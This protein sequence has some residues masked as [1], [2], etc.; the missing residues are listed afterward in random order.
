M[1]VKL[2]RL[3]RDGDPE[4]GLQPCQFVDPAAVVG[5]APRETGHVFFTNEAGN[6][7]SGV[8]E[9]TPYREAIDGYP[10]DELMVIIEG[11]VTITDADGVGETFSAGDA[12]LMPKGFVGAWENTVTVRKFFLIVE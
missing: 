5:A 2:V 9:A 1:S 12:F 4:S 8:W 11:A 7:T 6:A 3:R 10:V